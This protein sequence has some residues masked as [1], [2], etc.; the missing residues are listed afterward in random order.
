MQNNIGTTDGYFDTIEYQNNILKIEGWML[1]PNSDVDSLDVFINRQKV[2][3]A[4]RIERHDVANVFPQIP[5]AINSG[6]SFSQ[7]DKILYG[8]II[9][10]IVGM[11]HNEKVAKI[12]TI[13]ALPSRKC[14]ILKSSFNKIKKALTDI[15]PGL[16]DSDGNWSQLYG[17][18]FISAIDSRDEM[19]QVTA[20]Q[21]TCDPVAEY[22]AAGCMMVTELEAVLED[23]GKNLRKVNSFLDFACGYGRVTRFLVQE[24]GKKSITV[25]DIDK[26]AVDFCKK[27]FDVKG[28]YSV[29]DPDELHHD[30]KYDVIFV[31]S[32]FSHLSIQS[33]EAWFKRLYIMLENNG[34]LILST[35]GD[36]AYGLFDSKAKKQIENIKDGFLYL[37]ISETNRLSRKEYGTAYVK[38]EFVED[39]VQQNNIGK[40]IGF[41]P[42]G[43]G[44]LQDIYVIKK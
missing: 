32:L 22:F 6:F 13:Y 10:E 33:W 43:L 18:G 38:R 24:M 2:G 31:A 40:M 5:H 28:F 12:K 37:Q 36:Y 30:Y 11:L 44:N 9:I 42:K 26:D 17:D 20:M 8:A 23:S 1:N 7:T 39:F 15:S 21:K 35:H 25:S 34:V 3:T 27:T 29:S 19:Y 14:S 41:Y 16:V 4:K